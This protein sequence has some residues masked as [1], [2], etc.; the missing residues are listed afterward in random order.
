MKENLNK[1]TW[2]N[3]AVRFDNE[4]SQPYMRLRKSKIPYMNLYNQHFE[5]LIKDCEYEE[6]GK[7]MTALYEFIYKGQ[8]IWWYDKKMQNLWEDTLTKMNEKADGWFKW[9]E[10]QEYKKILEKD[11]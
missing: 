2:Y 1:D 7:F 3:K 11:F 6:I 4:R 5:R 10:E 9:K 8:V